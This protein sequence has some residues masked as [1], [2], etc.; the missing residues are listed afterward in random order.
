[1][2]KKLRLLVSYLFFT[3]I[4]AGGFVPSISAMTEDNVQIFAIP[5]QNGIGSNP[6]HI[7]D[8]LGL[9]N[10]DIKIN[11]VNTPPDFWADLGQSQCIKHLHNALTSENETQN[12]IVHASSQGTATVINYFATK[13][14]KKKQIKALILESVLISGNN[15]IK[16]TL[17][18]VLSPVP[19][20]SYVPLFSYWMPYLAKVQFPLYSPSGK[21]AIKSVPKI[22][23]NVLVLIIHS[24][25]DPQLSHHGACA[26]YYA[27]RKNGNKNVYLISTEMF[28][29]VNLIEKHSEH[30]KAIQCILQKHHLL[31]KK[32]TNEVDQSL[33]PYQPD[34]KKFKKQYQ[35]ILSIEKKHEKLWSSIKLVCICTVVL[36]IFYQTL[37]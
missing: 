28:G 11:K 2:L 37:A 12:I 15:A 5:G 26:L 19:F 29:H 13:N 18:G 32:N 25:K 27:L 22:P 21:Q 17:E 14:K 20:L 33:T 8:Y 24:K 6:A 10:D 35:K 36:V 7:K 31:S 4:F 9:K 1:M 23:S 3:A 34:Y 30:A 16:H